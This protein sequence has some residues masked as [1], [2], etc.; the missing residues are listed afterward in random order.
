MEDPIR[1]VIAHE[2]TLVLELLGSALRRED[3][4]ETIDEAT[5]GIQAIDVVNR[6][7][8]DIVL[9][10]V[11]LPETGGIKA[12]ESII[13]RCPAT[14]LLM[15]DNHKHEAVIFQALK[16]GATGY[17]SNSASV[18]DLIKAIHA[19]HRGEVWVEPELINMLI[20]S[21]SSIEDSADERRSKEF[22][23]LTTREKQVLQRL[24]F[25][26]TNKEIAEALCISEKTV[27]C[28]LGKIFR[29]LHVSRRLQAVLYAIRNGIDQD[30]V[31][32]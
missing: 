17:I 12:I 2:Q 6:Q 31:C 13:E 19:I 27:K 18:A 32:L 4:I 21:D 25:G 16:A 24:V 28:H 30:E 10:S 26:G 23:A 29:K 3:G 9:L 8:P 22:E 1:V 5:Q 7:Q 11:S 15:L 14:K 20:E